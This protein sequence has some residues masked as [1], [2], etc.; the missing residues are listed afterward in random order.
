MHVPLAISTSLAPQQ[1]T[2]QQAT[3]PRAA[4]SMPQHAA[5]SQRAA[6]DALGSGTA[7]AAAGKGAGAYAA[8]G[9][10]PGTGVEQGAMVTVTPCLLPERRLVS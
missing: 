6:A 5:G 10:A 1:A 3:D 7:A 4:L 8:A 2:A 9:G